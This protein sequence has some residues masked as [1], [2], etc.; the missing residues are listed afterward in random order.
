MATSLDWANAGRDATDCRGLFEAGSIRLWNPAEAQAATQCA[1]IDF[2]D[3]ASQW[4]RNNVC[5]D[6][7]F[8]G[9]GMDSIVNPSESGHDATD[10]LQLCAY[11]VISL[12][13]Y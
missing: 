7:R 6:P 9:L 11:G 8:E 2:G 4:A 12:R 5:D 3:D 10:C 1:A 13:D